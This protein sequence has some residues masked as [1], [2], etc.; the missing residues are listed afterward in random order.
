[1]MSSPPVNS[2]GRQKIR[3]PNISV[4]AGVSRWALKKPEGAMQQQ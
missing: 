2:V 4:L 1:M 3:E